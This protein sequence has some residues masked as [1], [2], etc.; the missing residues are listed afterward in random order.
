MK[1]SSAFIERGDGFG[2]HDFAAAGVDF[3][4]SYGARATAYG[5]APQSRIGYR[6]ATRTDGRWTKRQQNRGFPK[7]VF[8]STYPCAANAAVRG[9]R[10][11]LQRRLLAEYASSPT[12]SSRLAV[13]DATTKTKSFIR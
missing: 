8:R 1:D 7:T 5:M 2:P 6:L 3:L 9:R 11:A 10:A 12:P 4:N 13:V